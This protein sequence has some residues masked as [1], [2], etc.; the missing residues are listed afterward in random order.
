MSVLKELK[1]FLE[2]QLIELEKLKQGA[3]LLFLEREIQSLMKEIHKTLVII[4]SVEFND[5]RLLC[6]KC[7]ADIAAWE[8]PEAFNEEHICYQTYNDEIRQ[9]HKRILEERR[10]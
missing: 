4:H 9:Q 2:N 6:P 10:A 8:S 3:R 1:Q 5:Y 7:G